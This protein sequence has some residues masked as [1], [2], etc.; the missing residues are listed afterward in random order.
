METT[1]LVQKSIRVEFEGILEMFLVI[2]DSSRKEEGLWKIDISYGFRVMEHWT[3]SS[4]HCIFW[5]I[6]SY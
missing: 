1:S 2:V 5:G 3:F 4:Y 6:V